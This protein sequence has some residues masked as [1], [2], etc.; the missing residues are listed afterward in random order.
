MN[1]K[2]EIKDPFSGL[3]FITKVVITVG[4]MGGFL[5]TVFLF[6]LLYNFYFV[7]R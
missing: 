1:I 6:R 5:T 3:P 2:R 7:L 4:L